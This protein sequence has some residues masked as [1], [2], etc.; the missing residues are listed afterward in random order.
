MKS[1]R[2]KKKHSTGRPLENVPMRTLVKRV[3]DE[4]HD[5]IKMSMSDNA[6]KKKLD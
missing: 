1:P 2:K 5:R 4:L 6:D 3:K